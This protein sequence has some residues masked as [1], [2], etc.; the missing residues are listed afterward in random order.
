MLWEVRVSYKP[1]VQDPEG[2]STLEGLKTLGFEKMKEVRTAKV[3]VIK[4]DYS[5]QEVEEMC[6]RL[7]ANPISQDYE[8]RE[9]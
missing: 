8:I 5:R 6:K 2:D 1:G 9:L 3:Y 4:G 7:L